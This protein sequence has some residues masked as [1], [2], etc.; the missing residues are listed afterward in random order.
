MFKSQGLWKHKERWQHSA[1]ASETPL[2]DR[3]QKHGRDPNDIPMKWY[4]DVASGIRGSDAGHEAALEYY[5][6]I[7]PRLLSEKGAAAVASGGFNLAEA[8]R[9]RMAE[10]LE[11]EPRNIFF[12][13][14]AMRT[15]IPVLLSLG[16]QRRYNLVADRSEFNALEIFVTEN[17]RTADRLTF[18][19]F[20]AKDQLLRSF[21]DIAE[22]RHF[23]ERF[24]LKFVTNTGSSEITGEFEYVSDAD[25][26]RSPMP[27]SGRPA[28]GKL[29]GGPNVAYCSHVNRISGEKDL[30]AIWQEIE[31]I[32][33]VW[34]HIVDASHSVGAL[35]FKA[36]ELGDV[37][38]MNSSKALGGEPT[39][40]M[41][42]VSDEVLGIM[43]KELPR[44]SWPRI[45]FQFSPETSLAVGPKDAAG[46][47]HWVSLPE[48]FSLYATI[49]SLDVEE[50]AR[51][52][53][54]LKDYLCA[55]V[56]SFN[57][58]WSGIRLPS[59]DSAPHF[60]SFAIMKNDPGYQ[61]MDFEL[62]ITFRK[63]MAPYAITFENLSEH[64][65]SGRPVL[66]GFLYVAYAIR[67]SLSPEH[68]IEHVRGLASRLAYSLERGLIEDASVNRKN[69]GRI[70]KNLEKLDAIFFAEPSRAMAL[71]QS[72]QD[73]WLLRA[74]AGY[75]G[76]QA[77]RNA[78]EARIA[79]ERGK[80]NK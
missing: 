26:H 48:L 64:D 47:A 80:V 5:N 37:V 34:L 70:M 76:D 51:Q 41:C 61:S 60:V 16:R 72:T 3:T 43:E 58:A 30:R 40:G 54:K 21:D 44:T 6:D 73:E 7:T 4:F 46:C 52:M 71:V 36:A 24:G 78:A 11:C 19:N 8:A 68:S 22:M 57:A 18:Q 35:R 10:L 14:S 63:D 69:D 2:L 15:L 55:A 29:G 1:T 49:E 75:H 39:V 59:V 50:R 66:T 17:R 53:K 25:L 45:A 62:K 79:P 56:F 38:V 20:G 67:I 77:I 12:G 32:G 74:V 9:K 31:R 27:P 28:A 23:R 65:I 42:Y 33:P 13:N